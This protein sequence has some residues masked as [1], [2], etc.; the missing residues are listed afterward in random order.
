MANKGR[1]DE[2]ARMERSARMACAVSPRRASLFSVLEA[3][4]QAA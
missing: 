1:I 4:A 3:W 2:I